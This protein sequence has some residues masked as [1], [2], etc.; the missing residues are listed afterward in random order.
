[1]KK[2]KELQDLLEQV[3]R[4][5]AADEKAA[6]EAERLERKAEKEAWLATKGE[7]K[8]EAYEKTEFKGFD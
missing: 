6:R 4:K 5:T 7:K 2:E 3:R 8:M 1:M